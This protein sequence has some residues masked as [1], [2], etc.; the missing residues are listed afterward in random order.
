MNKTGIRVELCGKSRE[1]GCQVIIQK[2]YS[3]NDFEDKVQKVLETA[4]SS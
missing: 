4:K 3:I 2:P 1:L